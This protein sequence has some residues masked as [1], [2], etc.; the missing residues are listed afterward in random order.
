[1]TKTYF[2]PPTHY[3]LAAAAQNRGWAKALAELIDTAIDHNARRIGIFEGPI[4]NGKPAWF[5]I[6]DNDDGC[7]DPV[8]ITT[9][10]KRGD[11]ANDR[12]ANGQAWSTIEHRVG[13]RD[14]ELR[15]AGQ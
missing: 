2:T 7:P 11:V 8:V 15:E 5:E 12:Q 13:D 9:F 10:G 1:M 4:E 14:R 6:R 3:L